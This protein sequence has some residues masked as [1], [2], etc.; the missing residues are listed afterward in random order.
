MAELHWAR[1]HERDLEDCEL[2]HE[3]EL[4]QEQN[5]IRDD[6]ISWNYYIGITTNM[7]T[8]ARIDDNTPLDTLVPSSSQ[9]LGKADVPPQGLNLT[10]KGFRKEMVKGDDGDELKTVLHFTED[11]KPLILNRTNAELLGHATGAR[12]SGE[13]KGKRVNVYNDALIMF[14]AKRVGGLRLRAATV[15]QAAPDPAANDLDDEITF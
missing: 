13:A 4:T 1:R 9:Y 10:I 7:N 2:S 14:G 8:N 6:E 11:V 15:E 12:T 5:L 3:E